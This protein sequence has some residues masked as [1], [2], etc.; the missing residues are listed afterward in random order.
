MYKQLKVKGTGA[1]VQLI[2]DNEIGCYLEK[3]D[4]VLVGAEVILKNG[5]ILNRA[6]TYCL[7]LAAHQAGKKLYVFA[8]SFKYL[9][10]IYLCSKDIPQLIK[11]SKN[12]NEVAMDDLTPAKYISL[13][14]TDIG[15]F[16]PE[17]VSSEL[18]ELLQ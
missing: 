12:G 7:A 10:R 18:A 4:I 13:F 5:S 3:V 17:V 11:R 16:T 6:G 1:H 2:N 14:F 15:I 8:E 9:K